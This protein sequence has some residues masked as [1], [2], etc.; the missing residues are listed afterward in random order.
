MEK[1]CIN[2][3]WLETYCHAHP[4]KAGEYNSRGYKFTVKD[5]ET[6]TGTFEKLY[7]VVLHG[8]QCA[9]I[10]Q[11][12]RIRKMNPL[13]TLVKLSNR[14]LYSE[15]YIQVLY[16]IH[17]AFRMHYKGI[18]RLD[19]CYDCNKFHGGRNPERFIRQYVTSEV[20]TPQHMYRANSS[21]FHLVGN[22][23][24]SSA[25]SMQSI[26]WGSCKSNVGVY[27]YNKTLELLEVKDKPW[28]RETWAKNGLESVTEDYE[29]SK[30]S[31]KLRKKTVECH[32]LLK[33]VST[34]VWRMEISIKAKGKD[35]IDMR[36]GELFQLSPRYLES[37]PNIERL[38]YIYAKKY[39]D[40]R[41][42]KKAKRLRDYDKIELFECTQETTAKPLQISIFHDTGRS[43]KVCFNKLRRLSEE[44]SDIASGM[45]KAIGDTMRF[46]QMLSGVKHSTI[47]AQRYA[48]AISNLKGRK[49]IESE[50]ME[51]IDAVRVVWEAKQEIHAEY[52]YDSFVLDC[53]PYPEPYWETIPDATP[54]EYTW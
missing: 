35:I 3:D 46:I 28:I 15:Q 43:E 22:K 41:V 30:L 50:S 36:T 20:G 39:C 48:T 9:T 21:I 7:S 8:R 47:E 54:P 40:F 42:A 13:T 24:S 45:S 33:Y 18:T 19:L 17:E 4:I 23:R 1:Y 27:L 2:V 38:F 29:L 31:P 16:A 11:V 34:P 37:Q 52:L 26:R 5:E 49:W 14:V 44:Y 53:L 12:P 25:V 6:G 32:G 51:Y 10:Q